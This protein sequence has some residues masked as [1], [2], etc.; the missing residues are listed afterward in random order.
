[1]SALRFGLEWLVDQKGYWVEGSDNSR[2]IVP[3]GGALRRI[4]PLENDGLF[5]VFAKVR[6]DPDLLSFV[7]RYG[8]LETR[9]DNTDYG[10][11]VC[12]PDTM[13]PVQSRPVMFGESVSDHL[14]TAF[15]FARTLAFIARKGRASAKLSDFIADRLLNDELGHIG[16]GFYPSSGLTMKMTASTLLNGM[17][18]QLAQEISARPALRLCA[19][20]KKPFATGRN[21]GRRTHA[22][23]CSPDHKKQFHSRKRSIK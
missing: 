15:M 11:T 2:T 20:C 1:M 16:W 18:L 4:N 10:A 22:I 6:S 3:M 5:L 19:Y 8:L 9:G 13:S 14:E 23:F 12:D 7:Q 21:T 17:L